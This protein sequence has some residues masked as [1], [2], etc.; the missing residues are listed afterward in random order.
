MS[1]EI[2]IVFQVLN[3]LSG[4]HPI[5]HLLLPTDKLLLIYLAKYKGNK[6]IFPSITTLARELKM[7]RHYLMRRLKILEENNLI[8]LIK[9]HGSCHQYF[10]HI[11]TQTGDSQVTGYLEVTSDSQVTKLV[12]PRLRTGDSQ[13]PQLDIEELNKN[14]LKDIGNTQNKKRAPLPRKSQLPETFEPNETHLALLKDLDMQEE[15][16][17]FRDYH[18]TKATT[19]TKRGWDAAFRTWLRN[20]YKFKQQRGNQNGKAYETQAA[21]VARRFKE[22]YARAI[23]EEQAAAEQLRAM[24]QEQSSQAI[25]QLIDS[26]SSHAEDD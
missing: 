21:R 3:F 15:L 1:K 19:T 16:E 7:N 14:L 18:V 17:K 2:H 26:I 22:G 8:S 24:Q 6:G 23:A 4:S 20:A 10:I 9:K 11:P 12:T 25:D 13:V 5:T